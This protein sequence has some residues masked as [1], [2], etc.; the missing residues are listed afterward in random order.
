[1]R[2]FRLDQ[3]VLALIAL[4]VSLVMVPVS[5]RAFDEGGAHRTDTPGPLQTAGLT[6][7]AAPTDDDFLRKGLFVQPLFP[8]GATSSEE[9]IELASLLVAYGAELRRGN[10]DAVEPIVQFLTDHPHSAWKPALLVDLGAVYRRTGHYSKAL[11][12]WQAAWQELKGFTDQRGHALGDIAL[13][14][15]SQFEAYLGRKEM[16]APLLEE[17]RS[18]PIRGSAMELISESSSGLADMLSRPDV[19][20]KCGP[21][22]LARLLR[23]QHPANFTESRRVLDDAKSTP[24]G[25]SLSAVDAIAAD[26]GMQF[27]MAFRSPGAPVITPAVAHWKVGHFAALLGKDRSDRYAVGDPTFGEDI[28]ISGPTLDEESSGYFLVPA[29]PLPDGW[30]SVDHTEGVKV[31]GRGDTGSNHDDGATGPS[32]IKAFPCGSG[33]GCASWNVEAMMVSLSLHDEPLGYNPPFGPPIALTMDYSHRDAQ[34]PVVF[35][36]TN[37]GNKWTTNWLSYVTDSAGCA[38][39]YGGVVESS[40]PVSP[41][42]VGP[43]H[44]PPANPPVLDDL[45]VTGLLCAELF[46]RG[47]GTEPYVFPAWDVTN[48]KSVTS[49]I[50]QFSQAVL[51]R[52]VDASGNVISFIR[53][54]PDG[55]IERFGYHQGGPTGLLD[56]N[57][58]FFLTEVDDPQGNSVTISYDLLSRITQLRDAIGQVTTFCYNDTYLTQPSTCKKASSLVNPPSNLEVTQITD[59]FGRSAFFSY[60]PATGNL[61][62]IQDVLGITSEFTYA[63]GSDFINQLTTPYGTTSF[64]FTDST[65]DNKAGSSRSLEIT[66]SL[67]RV[68]RVEFRQGVPPCDNNGLDSTRDPSS[69]IATPI[70]CAEKNVPYD[71]NILTV[72]NGNLEYRN[73][74]IWDP[75]LYATVYNT[76]S[77]YLGAKI[78]HWLHTDCDDPSC[79][80]V[81]L[82]TNPLTASR[83]LESVKAPLENR[84]YFNYAGQ[85]VNAFGGSHGSSP[86]VGVG[87]TNQ[88]TVIARVLDENAQTWEY[89]Q[90]QYNDFGKLAQ[91]TDPIGRQLTMAYYTNGID[92]LSITNTTTVGN[93]QR[94]DLLVSFPSYNDQ[95]EPQLIVAANGKATTLSYNGAGQLATRMDPLGNAWTYSYLPTN[96][97][98]LQKITGPAAPQTP[99]YAF[100]YDTFGRIKSSTDPAGTML[101]YT[102]DPA[103]RLT[104]VLFPDQTSVALGYT[105]LDLTSVTD[106]RGNQA[107]RQYDG[108][109]ELF[110]IGEPA[111]RKTVLTYW[112]NGVV[113]TIQD[114]DGSTTTFGVDAAGRLTNMTYPDNTQ[115]SYQFDGAGR[116]T[117]EFPSVSQSGPPSVTYSYNADDTIAEVAPAGIFP[118]FFEYDPVYKRLAG[119]TQKPELGLGR[120]FRDFLLLPRKR[121]RRQSHRH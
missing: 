65:N 20:F 34:E 45:N 13:A 84:V 27:Q 97:G 98:Y 15:L 55:S 39:F 21:S 108:D 31:W 23:L 33:G 38:G 83:V 71:H 36:Y 64:K 117:T 19:A 118:T 48:P 74:F 46:R 110:Q 22:A 92:L 86:S 61:T 105:F 72:F 112:P 109:R 102:Y 96:G 88:P 51:T 25:L 81:R 29:G 4:T 43:A 8:V 114:P 44:G 2:Y 77:R 120:E 121:P 26:A 99:Q 14:Y 63:S 17:N 50:A 7:S 89:W 60:D 111:G 70:L 24:D 94:S 35:S 115:K 53:Y 62:E 28:A 79:A 9:N 42:V 56:T 59:P 12:T 82:D 52:N 66:D 113:N 30:R 101:T 40:V 11:E 107:T 90:Y 93:S 69:G 5:G 49:P 106:R 47:G 76:S 85:S 58:M 80:P 54:L 3:V 32:E 1:M 67:Q 91:I 116:I 57:V 10:R 41:G 78:L 37:F 75:Q 73:T 104:N 6:V 16:L 103:N 100:D 18:R 95:H 68:S 119:W 87:Q